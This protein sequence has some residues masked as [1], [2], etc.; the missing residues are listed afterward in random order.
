MIDTHTVLFFL[1]IR[2]PP[3]STRT[4][5]LFP[6]TTL[7][8]SIL[9]AVSAAGIAPEQLELEITEGVFLDES[10]ENLAMFQRLKRTGVRLA[11]DDF[12]TGYSA[13][14]YLKK[15]PFDKIKI[16]QRF[17]LGATDARSMNAVII[18]S[19]VG[20]ATALDL[21]TTA[22]GVGPHEDQLRKGHV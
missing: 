5:T 14:G 8:R 11:L 4:D 2:R 18:S 21:E 15:A 10:A 9:S 16:D 13:L 17:V 3:R 6:Y 22:G 7:F 1:M 12:G 19:I 20:L